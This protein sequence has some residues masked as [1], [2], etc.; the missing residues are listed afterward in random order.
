MRALRWVP[1]RAQSPTW[2]IQEMFVPERGERRRDPRFKPPEQQIARNSN[3]GV[4]QGRVYPT[5][6]RLKAD[7]VAVSGHQIQTVPI[8]MTA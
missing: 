2:L 3:D 4:R 5:E 1:E 7:A 6:N 8:A